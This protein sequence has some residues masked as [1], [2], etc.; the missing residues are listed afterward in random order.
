MTDFEGDLDRLREWGRGEHGDARHFRVSVSR[1]KLAGLFRVWA[2]HDDDS[3][4]AQRLDEQRSGECG[5][6]VDRPDANQRFA[7]LGDTAANREMLR[8]GGDDLDEWRR[9]LRDRRDLSVH[10][11]PGGFRTR[12]DG[13]ELIF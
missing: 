11:R 2:R 13:G 7:A 6:I 1:R 5:R 10:L 8:T 9:S 12:F 4:P 3:L